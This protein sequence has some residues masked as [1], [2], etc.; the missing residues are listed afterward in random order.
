MWL[1]ISLLR[2][3]LLLLLDEFGIIQYFGVMD[4]SFH[5]AMPAMAF[6][7][8]GHAP[9]SSCFLPFLHQQYPFRHG[10]S[11]TLIPRLLASI[12]IEYDTQVIGGEVV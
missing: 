2:I 3:H 6:G 8:G 5:L 7:F 1:S 12:C 10:S 9:L 4:W 11:A